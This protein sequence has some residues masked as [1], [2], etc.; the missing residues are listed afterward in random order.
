MLLVIWIPVR[1]WNLSLWENTPLFGLLRLDL[2][3]FCRLETHTSIAV[4]CFGKLES[5]GLL[6]SGVVNHVELLGL[7]L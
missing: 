7:N 2:Q 6:L 5:N 3:G 4:S 1:Q